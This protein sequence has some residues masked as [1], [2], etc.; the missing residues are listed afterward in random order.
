MNRH[1]KCPEAIIWPPAMRQP[2]RGPTQCREKGPQNLRIWTMPR[3]ISWKKPDGAE[4]SANGGDNN[5]TGGITHTEV[6]SFGSPTDPGSLKVVIEP[7]QARTNRAGWHLAGE[8]INRQP[9][10]QKAGLT[11]GTYTLEFTTVAG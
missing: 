11:P 1:R 2:G 4:T 5:T 3:C 6:T 9:G 8:K 7:E 10:S